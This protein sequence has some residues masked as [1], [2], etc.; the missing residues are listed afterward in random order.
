MSHDYDVDVLILGGS[1]LGVELVRQLRRRRRGRALDIAVIDRCVDHP[2]IPLTHELLTERLAVGV[3]AKTVLASADWVRQRAPARWVQGDIAAFDPASHVATL[4]DG[5]ALSGRFVVVALGSE[6][7]APAGLPGGELLRAYKFR[8]EFEASKAAIAERLSRSLSEGEGEACVVV[9]GGGITG[10]EMAGELAHLAAARPDGW[11]APKV[12]LVHGGDRLLPGLHPRGGRWAA[13]VL[14]EQGVELALST[15]VEAVEAV[16]GGDLRLR[17][18]G[19]G[20]ARTLDCALGFWAGGV[21]PPKVLPELGLP[22]DARGWLRVGPSLQCYPEHTDEPEIFAGGDVARIYGGDG[23]W[24]TMQRAIEAIFAAQAI[25]NNILRLAG[26][27]PDSEYADG[28]PPM[29]PHTLWR[30]FPHGVS[31]GARSLVIYGGLALPGAGLNIWF[32]RFLMRQ[33]MRRFS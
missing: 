29:H 7:R 17:L 22:L 5:S 33:Y 6:V 11:R 30:D 3:D 21:R 26:A 12:V 2:Y 25:A 13:R 24:P 9:V 10:V 15:R 32:R 28:V 18:S 16:E 1:F 19:Q 14:A 27:S 4:T 8:D 31:A 23:Q 20:S